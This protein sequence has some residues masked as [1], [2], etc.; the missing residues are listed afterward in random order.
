VQVLKGKTRK[1]KL[2]YVYDNED[3]LR[4]PCYEYAVFFTINACVFLW[5]MR[6]VVSLLVFIGVL[7]RCFER[8]LVLSTVSKGAILARRTENIV[9]L[10]NGSTN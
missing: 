7:A 10:S 3:D 9:T 1:P 2:L 6:S 5:L 8:F 4:A